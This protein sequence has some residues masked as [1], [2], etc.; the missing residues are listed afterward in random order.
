LEGPTQ[1]PRDYSQR[2]RKLRGRLGL[3]QTQLA[4][5]LG[6]SFASVNRWENGQSRPTRLAWQKLD[7]AE[8]L[9]DAAFT[10]AAVALV[11][12]VSEQEIGGHVGPVPLDFAGNAEGARAF[13]ESHWLAQGYRAN[14]AFAIETSLVDPLPHQRLAVYE[15]MLGQPRLRFLLA[16]DAGAGKTIMAGL[17][18]REMLSRRLLRR[19]LVVAPAGLVGNWHSEMH[20]LFRL[21]FAIVRGAD[22][23][24]GNPFTGAD[25]NLVIVSVDTLAGNRMLARLREPGTEPYDL[26][27]FDEA[28]KLSAW[29]DPDG[30][31]RATDRYRIAEALA[32]VPGTPEAWQLPWAARH[33]LLLTATPHMGKDDPYFYLWRLLDPLALST[34]EAFASFPPKARARHF[35][36]RTKEEMV[37]LDGAPLYPTRTSDTLSFE[38]SIAVPSEQ[39]LYDRT[40]AYIRDVYSRAQ[41]LNRPAARLA[42]SVFQRRLAS[43]TWAL[44]RSLER[45]IDKLDGL[46][47]DIRSGRITQEQLAAR[48]RDLDRTARDPYEEQTADEDEGS[49]GTEQGEAE[50]SQSLGGVVATSLADLLVERRTVE[51]LCDLARRVHAAGRESKFETLREVLQDPRYKHEKL[52]VFTEHRDTLEFLVRRFEALGFT[53]QVAAIHGGLSWQERER[54]VGLFRKAATDGGATYLIATDAAGEGINLQFCWLMVNYDV[55]W[56]PARLEQRMGRIHR[57]KQRHDPV[58]VINLVAGKT[59]EGRVVKTLLDKLEKIRKELRSDKVYDVIGRIFENVSIRQY[60]EQALTDDGAD[61]A[62]RRLD[63]SLTREQVD[64]LAARERA[65]FGA[66]GEV[67][68]ELPRLR[69]ELEREVYR[70]LLPGYVRRFVERV[71]PLLGLRIEGDLDATFAFVADRPGAM[72][73]LWRAL[74]TYPEPQ[75]DQLSVVKPA[76]ESAAVFLHPGEAVFDTLAAL[77]QAAFAGAARRGAIFIDPAAAG[78][79]LVH[80]GETVIERVPGD[81]APAEVVERRLLCITQS[82]S[83]Q[84]EEISPECLALLRPGGAPTPGALALIAAGRDLVHAAEAHVNDHLLSAAVDARRQAVVAA[85]PEREELLRRGFD[86]QEADLAVR[87]ARLAEKARAGNA[88]AQAELSRIREHQR[89]LGDQRERALAELRAEPGSLRPAPVS[90]LAHVLVLPSADPEERQRFDAE[91]EA[92]AVSVARAHEEALGATVRDVSKPP[93]ARAAGLSDWPGFDLLSRRPDGEERAIEVKGR[94]RIGDIELKENEWAKACNLRERYW[95]YVVYDCATEH[96]R[97]L[98]VQ[99]PFASLI[100]KAKGGVVIDNKA[101]QAAART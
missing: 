91:V 90:W 5:R 29:R 96:P 79:Y 73:A 68:G 24:A 75:R 8:R 36:R 27:V 100:V 11:D 42:M 35:I 72:D 86:F 89:R 47:D 52:I 16:D 101:V 22:A 55:P 23:R 82:S 48:Q 54:Q 40:T 76:D 67:S 78:P 18:I 92:V 21:P 53:G 66:G 56:N 15:R 39:E 30:T 88:A 4:E 97:L 1:P 31:F 93:L 28:H 84:T 87:R 3:T 43:S 99:D 9:G 49:D 83:G 77:V 65:L 71:A 59:R 25:S 58:V 61:E 63:G 12:V 98:R 17:Y 81:G 80:A 95:L 85:L 41:V 38:L 69:G 46:I 19:V 7:A 6:V 64:A 44:L 33:V 50:E 74:E 70:R 2:I 20:R 34:R 10:S 62:V 14:P 60:I 13:I 57:Y 26:A 37:T 51:E 94:A 45:R 32:G